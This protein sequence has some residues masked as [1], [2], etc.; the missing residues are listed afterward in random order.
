MANLGDRGGTLGARFAYRSGAPAAPI[1]IDA[2]GRDLF[3]RAFQA[4]LPNVPANPGG[5]EHRSL[6]MRSGFRL[7]SLRGVGQGDGAIANVNVGGKWV[8]IENFLDQPL[9]QTVPTVVYELPTTTSAIIATVPAGQPSGQVFSYV[10]N[11]Q[12]FW[13]QLV[14]DAGTYGYV[15]FSPTQTV[16][17]PAPPPPT[18]SINPFGLPDFGGLFASLGTAGKWIVGGL[19][20]LLAIQVVRK[21]A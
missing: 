12:G 13:W 18:G 17:P 15:L 19:V 11:P 20:A 3:A 7:T 9:V 4:S 1:P 2:G 6:V 10:Q 8:P 5:M 21:V 14:R 16:T